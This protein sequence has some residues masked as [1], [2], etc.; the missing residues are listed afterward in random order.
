MALALD[1]DGREPKGPPA[2]SML[3]RFVPNS[4]PACNGPAENG[5]LPQGRFPGGSASRSRFPDRRSCDQTPGSAATA[6]VGSTRVL[7]HVPAWQSSAPGRR[8][9]PCRR[10]QGPSR[11]K[12]GAD[13]IRV[14]PV[15]S[16][17]SVESCRFR[18]PPRSGC[19]SD[20]RSQTATSLAERAATERPDTLGI[21][22]RMQK[23]R[24]CTR[25]EET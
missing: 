11:R 2:A 25:R 1:R 7:L 3:G 8:R 24:P 10:R 4:P 9:Q 20:L 22:C 12:S 15:L 5:A 16:C 21:R 6:R 14:G 13:R 18:T 19:R 17:T 23:D